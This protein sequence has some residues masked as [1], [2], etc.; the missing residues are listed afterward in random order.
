MR[1]GFTL[2]VDLLGFHQSPFRASFAFL[3]PRRDG[4][5]PGPPHAGA[6]EF[7]R[8]RSAPTTLPAA[9]VPPGAGHDRVKETDGRFLRRRASGR[10]ASPSP[11]RRRRLSLPDPSSPYASKWRRD[12]SK[13][14]PSGPPA[15]GENAGLPPIAPCPCESC[16]SRWPR[17]TPSTLRCLRSTPS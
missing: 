9:G 10:R 6:S 4:E 15:S 1:V 16:E 17:R 2:A 11:R 12:A 14:R 3:P 7:L 8:C 5:R 13:W